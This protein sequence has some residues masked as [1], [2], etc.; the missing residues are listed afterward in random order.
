[1]SFSEEYLDSL[2]QEWCRVA[3]I[4][5]NNESQQGGFITLECYQTI[6][7][8]MQQVFQIASWEINS[9]ELKLLQQE[10]ERE[11]FM[12][13]RRFCLHVEQ[14]ELYDEVENVLR[15][16]QTEEYYNNK[17]E[18]T[19]AYHE[20]SSYIAY[21]LNCCYQLTLDLTLKMHDSLQN[22]MRMEDIMQCYVVA[23]EKEDP[24]EVGYLD[25]DR[26]WKVFCKLTV[27][28][29]DVLKSSQQVALQ[30]L[31]HA[32]SLRDGQQQQ[33]Q[34]N[35]T[36][37]HYAKTAIQALSY[38]IDARLRIDSE[39]GNVFSGDDNTIIG[40]DET[41]RKKRKISSTDHFCI[42]SETY[43]VSLRQYCMF[44][45]RPAYDY[46][47]FPT[48]AF[49]MRLLE[50]IEWT[51]ALYAVI[52]RYYQNT[53]FQKQV[54]TLLLIDS[55]RCRGNENQPFGDGILAIIISFLPRD[56]FG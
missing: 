11:R 49:R 40:R 10:F 30:N 25:R 56:S 34:Q 23:F 50:Q 5:D 26:L 15:L 33:Q 44:V 47:T 12:S 52:G 13:L 36:A 55:R 35:T 1:M 8:K 24:D 29:R 46:H 16:T 21:R 6:S 43:R 18:T 38:E 7:R 37:D 4:S 54:M 53:L 17:Q 41:K 2:L 3:T 27:S 48:P 39:F 42:T 19:K 28:H 14:D 45:E 51:P 32:A 22:S 20:E 31:F 9:E